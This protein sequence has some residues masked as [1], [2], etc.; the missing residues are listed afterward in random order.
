LFFVE[1]T[2]LCELMAFFDYL[3]SRVSK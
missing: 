3:E 1:W 2:V